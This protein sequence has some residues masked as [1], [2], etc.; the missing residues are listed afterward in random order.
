MQ[1]T[2]E[3]FD[4]FRNTAAGLAV[5]WGI[6]DHFTDRHVSNKKRLF[7]EL[8]EDERLT[9]AEQP[10]RVSVFLVTVDKACGQLKQRFD[11]LHTVATTFSVLFPSTLMSM[12]DDE[13]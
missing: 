7:D 2:R 5:A 13:L 9:C 8:C 1:C 11:S 10:L 12:S 4:I 3:K 6:K